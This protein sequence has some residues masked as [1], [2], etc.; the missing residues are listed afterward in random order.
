MST[1]KR[2]KS[3]ESIKDEYIGCKVSEEE[4]SDFRKIAEAESLDESKLS[5]LAHRQFMF[6]WREKNS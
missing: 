5:R 3:V 2:K 4:K 6:R 1:K